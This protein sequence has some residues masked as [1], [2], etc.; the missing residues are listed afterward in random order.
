MQ[1]GR[2]GVSVLTKEKIMKMIASRRERKSS[3][4]KQ[5]EEEQWV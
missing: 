4:F 3:G 5:N 1:M 2:D